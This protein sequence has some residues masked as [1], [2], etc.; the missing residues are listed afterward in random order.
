MKI[1]IRTCFIDDTQ[2]FMDGFWKRKDGLGYVGADPDSNSKILREYHKKLWSKKLP[3]GELMVLEKGKASDYLK[4]KD[5]RFAS[6]T[7][8]SQNR[9]YRCAGVINQVREKMPEYEKY[10]EDVLRKTYT[11][12]GMIIFPKKKNSMNQLRGTNPM[13]VDRWDL[14]LE[15][16]KRYYEEPE[17]DNQEYNPLWYAINN[18]K[19]FFELFVTF[20]GYVD[21][22]FLH[23]H[24]DEN[25]DVK[26]L[27]PTKLFEINPLPKNPEEYIENI[28]MQMKILEKRNARIKNYVDQHGL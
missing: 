5:M 1:D 28:E 18:S 20:E 27:I 23:D 19:E 15:C 2:G 3:N 8:I 4:W 9:Y 24:I 12:G 14:T 6:D 10:V 13:I 17:N 7:I 16:I 21:F 22:F 11:I 26:L 25:G